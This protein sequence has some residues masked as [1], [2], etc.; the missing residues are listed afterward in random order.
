MESYLYIVMKFE[1]LK[2]VKSAIINLLKTLDK[3]YDVEVAEL[4]DLFN[5][6]KVKEMSPDEVINL[7]IDISVELSSSN[8]I[9]DKLATALMYKQINEIN[10]R[11]E[12]RT[13]TE[14]MNFIND[15]TQNFMDPN[16]VAFVNE[17][18]SVFNEQVLNRGL[19]EYINYFGYTTLNGSYCIK[20]DGHNVE[21]PVDVIMRTAIGLNFKSDETLEEKMLAISTT[22]AYMHAGKFIHATPTLFNAGTLNNQMSSCYILG[23]EDSIAGIFDTLKDCALIS[24]GSGGIGMSISNVRA[25]DS[26]IRGTNGTSSGVI[27]MCKVYNNTAK[28]VDQGGKGKKRPGSFA[29][30]MEVWHADVI[31]LIKSKLQTGIEDTLLRDLFVGLWVPDLFM[32]KLLKDEDWYLMCPDECPGL[33]S[34]Y[35]QEFENLYQQYVDEKKYRQVIKPSVIMEHVVRSLSD[36]GIPYFMF[37]DNVNKKSNQS[38]IGTVKSSNLCCEITEVAN[39]NQHAV[40]NLASIAVNKFIERDENG[41]PV[42]DSSNNI[43]YNY[44]ELRQVA[45][46]ITINLNKIIDINSYPTVQAQNTNN[47]TRPIGVGIQGVMNMFMDMRIPF[48]SQEALDLEAKVMETIYYGCMEASTDLAIK[49][50]NPYAYFENSN[51]SRGMFQFDMNYENVNLMWDWTELKEKAKATGTYNSLLTALMPT[52][53]TSQILGNIECFEPIVSNFYLRKTSHGT[54]KFIN[55]NLV[56]D[57]QKLGLWTP[58]MKATII[59]N[60]GSIQDIDGI[61]DDIK[62]LYKTVWNMKQKWIDD[63]A[64]AR[65]PF[66]DQSQSMNLYFPTIELQKFQSAMVYAWKKGLKTGSYYV[67]TK[68]AHNASN[69]AKKD[70]VKVCN[71]KDKEACESCSA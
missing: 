57:L 48:E 25:A 63:H 18:G 22:F 19:P 44:E 33:D 17:H 61:P 45:Y 38:N 70:E 59:R 58:E 41:E 47:A 4:A 8:P 9:Y 31:D 16:Y 36:N 60:Q 21:T 14:K 28:Y 62:L 71:I 35:G 3:K 15:N 34:A 29:M 11:R 46:H 43:V 66:V 6:Y 37:K 53:S 7:L 12:L 54:F 67:H 52:A 24:K 69:M 42:R 68:P 32:N 39:A 65:A 5:K 2:S 1:T 56:Q 10:E 64:I 50:G 20:I 13:F 55:K 23:M 30:F 40:C 27:P 49:K 26:K 51:F